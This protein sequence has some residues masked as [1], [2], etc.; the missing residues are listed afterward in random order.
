VILRI[1]AQESPELEL[2]VERYGEKKFGERNMNGF[3]VKR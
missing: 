3:G 1:L 2:L